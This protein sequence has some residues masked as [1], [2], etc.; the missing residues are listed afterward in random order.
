MIAQ[1]WDVITKKYKAK[2]YFKAKKINWELKDT[3]SNIAS[4]L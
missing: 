1:R 3:I 2:E 4:K